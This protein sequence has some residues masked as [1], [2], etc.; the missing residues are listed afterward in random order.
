MGRMCGSVLE[1]ACQ[2]AIEHTLGG[3]VHLVTFTIF[4]VENLSQRNRKE[5]TERLD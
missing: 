1:K 2:D 4:Q 5:V 3:V